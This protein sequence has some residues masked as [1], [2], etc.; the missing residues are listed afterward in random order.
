LTSILPYFEPDCAVSFGSYIGFPVV[1]GAWL[2]RVPVLL[3]EQNVIPGMANRVSA[4][5]AETVAISFPESG[6]FFGEK[7]LLVG[8]LVRN[9]IFN[10]DRVKARETL[11]ILTG[12][13]TVL[14]FG[15]SGGAR[16][17]NRCMLEAAEKLS[18]LAEKVQFVHLTGNSEDSL[19]LRAR[20]RSCG[21]HASVLDYSH[22][23]GECYAGADLVIARSGASTVAEL[24]ASKV[25]SILVPYPHATGNHQKANAK[26][27]EKLGASVLLEE[28]PAL[29]GKLAESIRSILD[30][31]PVLASMRSAY[32]NFPVKLEDSAAHLA[33]AVLQ[34]AAHEKVV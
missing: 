30:S 2:K 18:D 9:D 26:V 12:R 28:S 10:A 8:N 13:T 20:Y 31:A 33:E 21:F 15:G 29:P 27:L 23:M 34:T 7:S 1:F 6:K 17:L 11:E 22:Q 32:K 25:P 3:H 4:P 16:S 5:F 14:I 24:I 19:E